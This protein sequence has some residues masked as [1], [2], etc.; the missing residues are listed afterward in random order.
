MNFLAHLALSGPT[1]EMMVGNLMGDFV[2]GRLDE[3]FPPPIQQG[4][5]LH[6]KIDRFAGGNAH[7]IRSRQR[8]E[9]RFG[10][11]RG[12]LV[13][14][15][16]DH[17]LALRW[18]QYH[19]QPLAGFIRGCHRTVLDFRQVLPRQLAERL[20]ELFGTWLPSYGDV[21]GIDTALKRMSVRITRVNPLG[22]GI[23]ALT[24]NYQALED[25]FHLFY[26]ELQRFVD[27][28]LGEQ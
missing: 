13:D 12:V 2:K 8:I 26:P 17:F 4:L 10:L 24:D 18:Q 3:R 28:F 21:A 5:V 16:F 6:R 27:L 19:S 22:E 14:L 23:S 11:F 15:F 25:D 20:P 9:P 1:P 7:F